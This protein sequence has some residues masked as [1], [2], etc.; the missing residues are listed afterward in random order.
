MKINQQ[1]ISLFI[2]FFLL[3][4]FISLSQVN[5]D[6]EYKDG[7]PTMVYSQLTK[8][9]PE[10]SPSDLELHPPYPHNYDVK[11]YT[12]DLGINFDDETISGTTSIKV[13]SDVDGLSEITFNLE[14]ELT[15]SNVEVDGTNL[16]YNHTDGEL[17]IYLDDIYNSGEQF[18]VDITYSGTP[19]EAFNFTTRGCYTLSQ[20]PDGYG[21]RHWYPCYDYLDDKS[22]EG[23]DLYI[24]VP[25][26]YTV[27]SNG[28]LVGETQHNGTTEYHWDH[29]Y[30]IPTYLICL[31][32]YNYLQFSDTYQGMPIEHFVYPE[33][34]NDAQI[35][36]ERLPEMLTCY[37]EI[38]SDYKFLNEKYGHACCE[39]GGGMEHTTMTSIGASLIRPD[40]YCDWLYAH[41]LAHQWW[42][43][44]VT[45]GTW[46]DIWLN[47]GF[48][49]YSDALWHEWFHGPKSFYKRMQEFKRAYTNSTEDFPIHNPDY[50]W[51]PTVYEKGAWILHMMRHYMDDNGDDFFGCLHNYGN[52]HAY[53]FATTDEFQTDV[54]NFTE[55]DWDWFF[56]QWVYSAGY[57]VYEWHWELN[58]PTEVLLHISQ[59]Q[60]ID[61]DHPIFNMPVDIR[62]ET[63]GGYEDTTVR[64]D[65]V[66]EEFTLNFTNPVTDIDLDPEGWLLCSEYNPSEFELSGLY[67]I[68]T[69]EGIKINWEIVDDEGV[70]GFNLYR[71]QKVTTTTSP[72]ISDDPFT[73]FN[74]PGINSLLQDDWTRINDNL[75]ENAPYYYLD[76]NV[77]T[78]E[79]YQYILTSV[80]MGDVEYIMGQVEVSNTLKPVSFELL[81]LFPNPSDGELSLRFSI[82]KTTDIY[83]DIYDLAG[84]KVGSTYWST[85]STGTRCEDLELPEDITSGSYILNM[86]GRGDKIS[87]KFV[88]VK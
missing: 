28:L 10:I 19:S 13:E 66:E 9:R 31:H 44:W 35:A 18:S 45:C 72:S 7:F 83:I 81:S 49:T 25:D 87:R 57:P 46:M 85:F 48:A 33:D 16:T 26:N 3:F 29:N 5:N 73:S 36:F 23:V 88:V 82:Y 39:F 77:E 84:R 80:T 61:S 8:D 71:K 69:E 86:S 55:T 32:A 51:G 52:N 15:V 30:P 78:D 1:L 40:Y 4:P 47:E 6:G 17:L 74:F 58:S 27:A 67:A 76:Q 64:V 62:A 2:I 68:P 59:V 37:K 24:T 70:A 22:D 14:P 56:D 11:H 65:E 60:N 79:T 43:D 63:D 50:M 53:G 41:E 20:L 54:E 38:Y 75:I 42:G 12:I 34:Y 21:A